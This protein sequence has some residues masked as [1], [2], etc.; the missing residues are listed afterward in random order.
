MALSNGINVEEDK[1][2]LYN[3]FKNKIQLEKNGNFDKTIK[4]FGA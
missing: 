4:A 3:S 2:I 1:N